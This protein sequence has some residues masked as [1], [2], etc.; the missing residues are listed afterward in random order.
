MCQV[1]TWC[2]RLITRA[3]KMRFAECS[4]V[5]LHSENSEI[6]LMPFDFRT[7]AWPDDL[8][9]FEMCISQSVITVV[10]EL[11]SLW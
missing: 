9:V 11:A 2:I 7:V 6:T 4:S 3:W 8:A 5:H 10:A 1:Y